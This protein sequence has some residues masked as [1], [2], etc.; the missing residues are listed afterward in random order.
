MVTTLFLLAY[1]CVGVVVYLLADEYDTGPPLFKGEDEDEITYGRGWCVGVAVVWP[2][3][4]IMVLGLF[5]W[6]EVEV[7]FER[8]KDRRGHSP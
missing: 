5:L 3:I 7:Y 2:L 1:G 6:V 4:V 8:R